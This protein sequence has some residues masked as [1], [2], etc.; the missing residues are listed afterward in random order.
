MAKRQTHVHVA[1]IFVGNIIVIMIWR[2]ERGILCGESQDL[3]ILAI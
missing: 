2:Y 1:E 3:C